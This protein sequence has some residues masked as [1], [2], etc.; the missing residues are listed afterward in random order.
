MRVDSNF[1]STFQKKNKQTK[2]MG[3]RRAANSTEKPRT[4]KTGR[5][6]VV[7]DRRKP[8]WTLTEAMAL[9]RFF[10]SIGQVPVSRPTLSANGDNSHL[11][12]LLEGNLNT[13]GEQRSFRAVVEYWKRNRVDIMA[14]ACQYLDAENTPTCW[15]CL[16]LARHKASCTCGRLQRRHGMATDGQYWD[17]ENTQPC[18][19]CKKAS[20]RHKASCTC[21]PRFQ[22]RHG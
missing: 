8:R 3:A 10:V 5:T 17:E 16:L 19:A 22:R 21:R 13:L 18:W 20:A 1:C 12:D 7:E 14:L 15:A 11:R 4:K 9:A 2:K 6:A